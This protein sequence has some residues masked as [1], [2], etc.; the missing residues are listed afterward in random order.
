MLIKDG[1]KY[2]TGP[3]DLLCIL[4]DVARG[5]FHAAFFEESPMPGPPKPLSEL[6][7]IRLK[8]KMH[9]TI[10]APDLAGAKVHVTEMRRRLDVHDTCV[11]DEPL[12][13][14]GQIPITFLAVNW[15]KDPMNPRKVRIQDLVR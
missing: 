13:W 3:C 9:H 2:L 15:N 11:L 12:D 1:D 6:D 10:G 7:G 4:H 8:S 14:N 5:T